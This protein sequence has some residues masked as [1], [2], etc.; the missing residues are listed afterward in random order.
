MSLIGLHH[1][2]TSWLHRLPAG[3]KLL[4]LV[5]AGLAIAL[6]PGP[7]PGLVLLLVAAVAIG[8]AR[9]GLLRTLH[10]LRWL[11][12]VALSVGAWH[13]WLN[14]WPRA[15][16][17]VSELLGLVLLATAVTAATRVE[18]LLA[19]L[20]K[21]L[22]PLRSLGV[23]PERFALACSLM[24]RAIPTTVDLATEMRQAAL[25]RGLERDPRALL[26]PF[27]IRV[28]ARARATGEALRARGLDD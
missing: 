22:G 20:T 18:D 3:A 12:L 13:L 19:A 27:V 21:A 25:A 2:G 16:E 7:A 17:I 5:A 6:V 28:V 4:G 10:R 9:L 14:G 11:G 8:T 24:L 23:D 15:V 26:V 1:P